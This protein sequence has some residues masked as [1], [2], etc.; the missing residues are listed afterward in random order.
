MF[1]SSSRQSNDR[2]IWPQQILSN[3]LFTFIVNLCNVYKKILTCKCI[4]RTFYYWISFQ[5]DTEA[6]LSTD[7]LCTI[8][9][10]S[11]GEVWMFSK[12]KNMVRVQICFTHPQ[13]PL[14]ST[15]S[16]HTNTHRYCILHQM[17]I[18]TALSYSFMKMYIFYT[19]VGKKFNPLLSVT[20]PC[21]TPALIPH[22]EIC[23]D[24]RR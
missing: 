23:C 9:S 3:N 22:L 5:H 15:F 12:K 1:V 13:A 20:L 4:Y 17:R 6:L 14:I 2:N 11:M 7:D 18:A 21:S 16:L 10:Y 19:M 24:T 8:M